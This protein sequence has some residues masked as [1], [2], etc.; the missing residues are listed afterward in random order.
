VYTSARYYDF[1]I[2]EFLSRDPLE[3]ID[4]MSMYRAYFGSRGLDPYGRSTVLAGC[5]LGAIWSAGGVVVDGIVSGEIFNDFGGTCCRATAAGVGGCVTGGFVGATV[6][7]GWIGGSAIGCLGG[8]LGSIAQK[9][10]ESALGCGSSLGICDIVNAIVGCVL[11]GV[12]GAVSGNT[13]EVVDR[14]LELVGFNFGVWTS[15]C[16][17]GG[18]G[19]QV[20][21]A[22]CTF[23]SNYGT[24]QLW[25]ETINCPPGRTPFG[26][27]MER[28]TGWWN[29]WNVIGAKAGACP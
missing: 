5:G 15:L 27:C 8:V 12:G 7:V 18:P 17:D 10:T 20:G 25:T 11:G 9:L 4:G 26:C 3:F 22:C 16:E 6:G 24:G 21:K 28:A 29:T 19:P 2:G 1:A 23:T 14:V 13:D